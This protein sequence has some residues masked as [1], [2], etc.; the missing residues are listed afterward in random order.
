[1]TDLIYPVT[2]WIRD[3]H[4]IPAWAYGADAIETDSFPYECFE[5]WDGH[6]VGWMYDTGAGLG[7]Q[8]SQ[9]RPPGVS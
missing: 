3:V 9:D 5:L 4:R 8:F 7:Y 6:L 2:S 1:M